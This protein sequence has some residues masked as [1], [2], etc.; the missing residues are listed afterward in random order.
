MPISKAAEFERQCE[1]EVRAAVEKE[2]GMSIDLNAVRE[3][4]AKPPPPSPFAL[5][6]EKRR[7]PWGR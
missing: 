1:A 2:A 5:L 7:R 6:L 4:L 3:R